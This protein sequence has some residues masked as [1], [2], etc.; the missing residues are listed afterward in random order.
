MEST[1]ERKRRL[2]TEG[3]RRYR[4]RIRDWYRN[5]KS[6]LVCAICGDMTTRIEF[7]HNDSSTKTANVANMIGHDSWSQIKNEISLCTPVCTTCHKGIHE[8]NIRLI[9]EYP[10]VILDVLPNG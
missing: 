3:K 5:Y 1:L 10:N 9:E 2:K 8:G 7:H 6:H 4:K